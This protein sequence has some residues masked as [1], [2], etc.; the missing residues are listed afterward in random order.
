[1]E[2]ACALWSLPPPPLPEVPHTQADLS[3]SRKLRGAVPGFPA[4]PGAATSGLR[5]RRWA[6]P[7]RLTSSGS[8]GARA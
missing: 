6:L 1:M 4:A 2:R 7:E 8:R 3:I 5:E